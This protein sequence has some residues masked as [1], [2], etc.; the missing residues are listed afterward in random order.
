MAGEDAVFIGPTDAVG[1][2]SSERECRGKALTAAGKATS[3]KPIRATSIPYRWGWRPRAEGPDCGGPF[4]PVVAFAKT[5][6]WCRWPEYSFPP[7]DV[8]RASGRHPTS[9]RDDFVR[10]VH[11]QLVA[12]LAALPEIHQRPKLPRSARV[13]DM[14]H[15]AAK[16]R[17]FETVRP[18]PEPP[19]GLF[20]SAEGRRESPGPSRLTIRLRGDR[21]R[22]ARR[23][24]RLEGRPTRRACASGR[25]RQRPHKDTGFFRDGVAVPDIRPAGPGLGR[26]RISTRPRA[27]RAR[28][29]SRSPWQPVPPTGLGQSP[30]CLRLLGGIAADHGGADDDAV[31]VANR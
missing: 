26:I 16:D 5:S 10:W 3:T 14:R 23:P 20:R 12:Q 29:R 21:R 18:N 27:W 4:T 13:D 25:E 1:G 15:T 11:F 17:T 24:D 9:H 6:P 30:R 28:S 31:R 7:P 2:A 8:H 19:A 22:C